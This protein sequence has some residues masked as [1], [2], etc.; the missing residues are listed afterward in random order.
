M[1]IPSFSSFPSFEPVPRPPSPSQSRN[2]EHSKEAKRKG[3]KGK[4]K[5]DK[6]DRTRS[7]DHSIRADE[8][9]KAEEDR[10]RSDEKP[11]YYS[12]RVGDPLNLR[13]G[14][15]HAGDVPK[16][17]LFAGGKKIL[18]LSHA[19]TALYRSNKGV[20]VAVGSRRRV[21]APL[22]KLISSNMRPRWLH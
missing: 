16:Y 20:E 2:P 19:W 4:R 3:D 1:S 8:R 18:G 10:K 7:T 9:R 22:P 15:L 14:G 6:S 12:D 21:R 5:R 17:K 13:Y 11:L